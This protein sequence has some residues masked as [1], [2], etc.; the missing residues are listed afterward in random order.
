MEWDTNSLIENL[1]K[2]NNLKNLIPELVE[3]KEPPIMI[4]IR[5]INDRS[6]GIF[7]E[8]PMLEIEL[9]IAKKIEEKLFSL[10]KKM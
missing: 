1:N 6:F 8:I 2:S 5:N 9:H 7:V 10:F 4:K 3:K